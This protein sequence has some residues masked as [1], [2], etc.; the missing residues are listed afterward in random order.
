MKYWSTVP[1]CTDIPDDL[2][3]KVASGDVQ[4]LDGVGREAIEEGKDGHDDTGQTTHH[5]HHIPYTETCT[6]T[7]TIT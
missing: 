1:I 4:G 7:Q 5:K 6:H 3:I 2:S